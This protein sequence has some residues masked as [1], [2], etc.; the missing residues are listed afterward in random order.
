MKGMYGI[1]KPRV[2]LLNVGTEDTKGNEIA[3]QTFELLKEMPIKFVGNMEARD[4][5]SGKYD[6]VVAD[7][8]WGNV[9]LKSTEGAVLMM[10]SKLKD[11]IYNTTLTAKIGGLLLKKNFKRIKAQLDYS[12]LGGAPFLGV[13]KMVIKAHG[14]SKAK[15]VCVAILQAYNTGSV[16]ITKNIEEE[17]KKVVRYDT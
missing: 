9:L 2:A 15:S 12:N 16:N 1:R 13:K 11:E 10:L 4:L 17:L 3:K 7:G 6:V 5:L 14:S 8:F